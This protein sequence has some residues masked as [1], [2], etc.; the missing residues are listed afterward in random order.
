MVNVSNFPHPRWVCVS[1]VDDAFKF[2]TL[3]K[4]NEKYF[5]IL[6]S[7]L[8]EMKNIESSPWFNNECLGFIDVF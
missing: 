1:Y 6:F 3:Y 2:N 8:E 4:K 7:I 5:G